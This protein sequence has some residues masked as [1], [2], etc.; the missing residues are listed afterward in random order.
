MTA[1]DDCGAI[2][3][4]EWLVGDECQ[5]GT[6][7]VLV[8][9]LGARLREAGAQVDRLNLHMRTLHPEIL[10]HRVSWAPGS[11]ATELFVG[12]STVHS[13]IFLGSSLRHVMTHKEWVRERLDTPEAAA[14]PFYE[15][16]VAEGVVEM[17]LAPLENADGTVSAVSIGTIRPAGFTEAEIRLFERIQKPLRTVLELKTLRAIGETLL[18]TYIGPGTGKRILAGHIR[19]GDMQLVDA[20]LMFCD[21]RGFTQLSNRVAH[22]RIIELLNLY[23]DQIVPAINAEGGEVLKFMGDGILAFFHR[24][25]GPNEACAAAPARRPGRPRPP[26]R[27]ARARCRAACRHGVASRHRRLRQCRLGPAP[28]LHRHRPRR[29]SDQPDRDGVQPDFQA[30]PD[31][32]SLRGTSR[33]SGDSIDRTAQLE[34]LRRTDRTVQLGGVSQLNRA[35]LNDLYCT[36]HEHHSGCTR[37]TQYATELSKSL[38]EPPARYGVFTVECDLTEVDNA[39]RSDSADG[40]L[41]S[42]DGDCRRHG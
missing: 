22:T 3:I 20:A 29:Q 4:V 6:A 41:R 10:A 37:L 8:E 14:S 38:R 17:V 31:V 21:L 28:R 5:H 16:F 23:F 11:E 2:E 32:C 39:F 9:Q 24:D 42:D 33:P 25:A 34:R 1:L 7:L 18:E 27:I 12:H 30:D 15:G 26:R 40:D 19:R 35:P 36:R 13:P